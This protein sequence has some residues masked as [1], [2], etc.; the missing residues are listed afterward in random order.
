M[1]TRDSLHPHDLSSIENKCP[2]NV[3]TKK[4]RKI[5]IETRYTHSNVI[6][7]RYHRKRLTIIISV[8]RNI[9][10]PDDADRLAFLD[11]GCGDGTYEVLLE[12]DFHRLVGLD[13][14]PQDLRTAKTHVGDKSKVD[15][16]L[17]DIYH[18]PFN[19]RSFDV[20]LCSEV[21]EHLHEPERGLRELSYVFRKGLLLTVP[22]INV[23][24]LVAKILRYDQRLRKVEA[25]IGHVSLHDWRWWRSV[26]RE[27]VKNRGNKCLVKMLHPY[28]A[29]APF[30]RIFGNYRNTTVIR[31]IDK[32]LSLMERI[33]SHPMSANHLVI[34][35]TAQ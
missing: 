13:I 4:G 18:L 12:R 30:E 23:N 28:V 21:L 15:F 5:A 1:E 26:F 25:D 19:E 27:T 11:V 35:I 31:L 24:R 32:S 16:I 20:V 33:L 17:G 2:K 3:T 8:L 34:T 22:I 7:R 29:S 14:R 9:A 10:K 6:L